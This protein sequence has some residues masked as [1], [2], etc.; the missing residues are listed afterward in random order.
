MAVFV[1]TLTMLLVIRRI[2]LQRLFAHTKLGHPV[3]TAAIRSIRLPS[4]LWC[5]AAALS[6]T[7]SQADI[8]QTAAVIA[9]RWILAFLIVSLCMAGSS[10]T[11]RALELYGD[12][13]GVEFA[14]SG[15][16]HAIIRVIYF[17]F[18]GVFLLW[19]FGKAVTPALTA[20]GVGGLAVAWAL[21]DTLANF[22]AGIHVMLERPI[23][24]GHTVKLSESEQGV[25]TDIGWRTTR[26]VTGL[27][28]VI[29]VPN[30]KITSAILVN[31]S[32]PTPMTGVDIPLLVAH[33]A[34]A[35]RVR[36]I[37]LEEIGA[38]PEILKE[39]AAFVMFHPGFRPSHLEL[40]LRF[41]AADSG[42]AGLARSEARYRIHRR[43]RSEGIPL[44]RVPAA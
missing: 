16:A 6:V 12:R 28:A 34:D 8:P 9:S 23:A 1:A 3:A 44:P 39:P 5:L 42:T 21:Q 36:Q 38:M 41:F 13:L 30:S 15:L 22:F 26:L 32:L 37:A 20:L 40:T 2:A 24:V 4:F 25:V 43:M 17:G 14:A 29:V 18:G 27:N 10:V 19:L 11:I 33:E 31:N 7:L 35:D